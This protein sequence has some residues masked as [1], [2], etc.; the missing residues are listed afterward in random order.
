MDLQRSINEASMVVNCL[1]GVFKLVLLFFMVGL[2]F[3]KSL[4]NCSTAV[5]FG[6][7]VYFLLAVLPFW[8]KI[9]NKVNPEH[10]TIGAKL[11][12]NKVFRQFIPFENRYIPIIPTI[13]NSW[14]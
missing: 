9:I 3:P 4:F 1:V 5:H 11:N 7:I 2:G 12:Q 13:E 14:S 6:H 8:V 10:G